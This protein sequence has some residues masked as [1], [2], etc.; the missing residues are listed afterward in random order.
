MHT[1]G[2]ASNL[3]TLIAG[4]DVAL[5]VT[6]TAVST[7]TAG[8]MTPLL[9]SLILGS[10]VDVDTVSLVYTTLQ[11]VLGPVLFGLLA[12]TYVIPKISPRIRNGIDTITPP[13]SGLLVALICGKVLSQNAAACAQAGA[14]LLLA[15]VSLH[16][17]GFLFGWVDLRLI[18]L[19]FHQ[20]LIPI[21]SLLFPCRYLM[22]RVLGFSSQVSRTVSIETGM[23]NSALATVLARNSF[24]DPIT[25]LPGAISAVC[26]S[27][28]GSLL[29]WIWSRSTQETTPKATAA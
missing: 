1:G 10:L 25:G 13:L 14:P 3:V 26:H 8:V 4:A 29:A 12:N 21:N 22:S 17:L 16:T 5:S 11:V 7:I 9:T 2:T 23:Q 15:I 27:L 19:L 24:P 20:S 28:V 6:M 18:P